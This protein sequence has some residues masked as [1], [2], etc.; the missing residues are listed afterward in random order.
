MTVRDCHADDRPDWMDTRGRVPPEGDVLT[1]TTRAPPELTWWYLVDCT[2]SGDEYGEDGRQRQ[3][4]EAR[5]RER[6][7]GVPREGG[8]PA[9]TGSGVVRLVIILEPGPCYL[10]PL[11]Y[12][13][14]TCRAFRGGDE[15][16]DDSRSGRSTFTHEDGRQCQPYE[17]RPDWCPLAAGEVVVKAAT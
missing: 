17:E 9:V 14:M 8:C 3:P 11:N 5:P 15:Y 2:D 13:G 4:Y 6:G 16:G 10:C 1:V 12:D 7:R